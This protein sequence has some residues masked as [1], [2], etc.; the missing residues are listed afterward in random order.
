M[1]D[2]YAALTLTCLATAANNSS[3]HWTISETQN[4]EH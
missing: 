1:R 4:A 3:I 2:T